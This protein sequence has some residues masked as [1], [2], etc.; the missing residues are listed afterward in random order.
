VGERRGGGGLKGWRLRRR[1]GGNGGSG[2]G[3]RGVG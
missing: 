3:W 2:I 1:V